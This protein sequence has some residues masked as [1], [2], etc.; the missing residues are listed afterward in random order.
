MHC[1]VLAACAQLVEDQIEV[2][3]RILEDA[4]D[5]QPWWVRSAYLRG[6]LWEGATSGADGF[7]LSNMAYSDEDSDT[8]SDEEED[9]GCSCEFCIATRIGSDSEARAT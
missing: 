1:A 5:Q 6:S 4:A 7:E 9:N 2:A 3:R 8:S